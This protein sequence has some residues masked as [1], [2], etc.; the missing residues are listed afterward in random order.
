VTGPGLRDTRT[1]YLELEPEEL[2][3]P[4]HVAW[5]LERGGETILDLGCATGGYCL[6][7]AR[8][9][10]R[11]TGVDVN[12]AYVERA[13][14]A[15]V[16]AHHVE[17]GAPLPLADASVDTVLLFEVLEHVPEPLPLLREARRVARRNV[18]VTVPNTRAQPLLRE[19]SLSFDHMLDVDHVRFFTRESLEA[20]L[21]EAFPAVRVD[22]REHKDLSLY[23]RL[24]PKPLAALL[25]GL[26]AVRLVRPKL[27]YR[28]FAEARV[29]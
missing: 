27:S 20:L 22:E 8:Q 21:L 25:G 13:R 10:R 23:L 7:L 19:A 4:A 16:D 26:V 15:G 12:A 29:A 5:A 28:L 3:A 11:C 14:A 6:A 9:G 24:L 2:V 1:F 18:L 17:P